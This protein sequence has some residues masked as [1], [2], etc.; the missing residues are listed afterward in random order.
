MVTRQIVANH[1]ANRT[2]RDVLHRL[3]KGFF[4]RQNTIRV[5]NTCT[6][7]FIYVHEKN[8]AF[9]IPIFNKQHYFQISYTEFQLNR[10]INMETTAIKAL[11][12]FPPRK[13][14]FLLCRFLRNSYNN[15]Q[16]F[17]WIS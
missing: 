4:Y 6:C 10:I 3:Y 5:V 7:R 13:V 1:F 15:Y 12:P 16:I 9:S 11:P 2:L 17:V 8:T 14:W